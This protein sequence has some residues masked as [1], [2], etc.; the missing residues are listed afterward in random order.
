LRSDRYTKVV[1]TVIAACLSVL[2]LTGIDLPDFTTE[3]EASIAL[4]STSAL[5]DYEEPGGENGVTRAPAATLPLRWTIGYAAAV[6]QETSGLIECLTA[7]N[8]VSMAP[9]SVSVE[10]VFLDD[11]GL[12][13]GTTSFS[14]ATGNPHSSAAVAGTGNFW[15]LSAGSFINTGFFV[16]GFARVYADDPRVLATAFLQCKDGAA[17]GVGSA[18]QDVHSHANI[19]AFPVGTTAQYFTAG[20]PATWTPPIV[21]PEAPE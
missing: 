11:D 12:S 1:L 16:G 15:P 6:D 13:V 4:T 3:A 19:P 10:V 14:L 20:M 8:L 5:R 2:T 21:L 17:A 9:G 7:I 18:F